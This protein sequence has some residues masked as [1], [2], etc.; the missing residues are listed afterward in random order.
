MSQ[1]INRANRITIEDLPAE[2]VELSEEHLQ[3]VMGGG[4][5]TISITITIKF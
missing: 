4:W 3:Q 2:L 5:P 1:M